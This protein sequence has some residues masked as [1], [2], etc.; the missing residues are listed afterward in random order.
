MG[1]LGVVM[2]ALGVV[3]GALPTPMGHMALGLRGIS[4][5]T[6]DESGVT[7]DEGGCDLRRGRF[8][9]PKRG[10]RRSSL[11]PS[12]KPVLS[13]FDEAVL[14]FDEARSVPL[15]NTSTTWSNIAGD[16]PTLEA[17]ADAMKLSS[18]RFA[19]LMV[20]RRSKPGLWLSNIMEGVA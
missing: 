12:T 15:S 3:M 10:L 6:F 11:W 13:T 14:A 1:A 16:S 20:W 4:Y 5:V 8:S 7:F 19:A 18:S 9:K 17:C 2:G